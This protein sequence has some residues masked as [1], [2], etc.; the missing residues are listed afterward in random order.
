MPEFKACL[1]WSRK[2]RYVSDTSRE[3]VLLSLLP[4]SSS[5]RRAAIAVSCLLLAVVL[6]TLP[7]ARAQWLN[8]PGF[9]LVQKTLMLVS[10]LITAALLFGQYAIG[11]P[12]ALNILGGGY[13]FTAL[14]TVPHAL[15]FPGVFSQTGLLGA[16]PQS[17]AYL[18][19]AAH[20]ALPVT[21]IGF[22][23]HRQHASTAGTPP[24]RVV[25]STI[26]TV[27]AVIAAVIATA[28]LVTRGD[29]CLPPLMNG[30]YYT[31]QA[32]V[33][34]GTLLALPFAALLLLAWKAR[35]PS[36]LALWLMVTMFAWLCTITVGAFVSRGRYDVGWYVGLLLDWLTSIFV[37]L[38]LI[39]ETIVLYER[40]ASAAAVERR[41]RDRRI[42][43]MEAVLIHLSRV[44]ELGQNVSSIVHEL[45]QPLTAISNYLAAGLQLLETSNTE[46]LKRILQQSAEQAARAAELIRQLR[47]FIAGHGPEKRVGSIPEVLRHAVDLASIGI[48]PP[49]P[50][51]EMRL[52]SVASS[53]FFDR[54]QIEQV[55]FNLVRNAIEAMEGCERRVLTIATRLTADNMVEVS[56]ADTGT[57]VSPTIRTPLFEPF[58]TTKARGLGIGL[59]ICRVIVEAH[60]GRLR[61]EDNP[62]GGAIFRFALPQF[63]GR[64]VARER[65]CG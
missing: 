4:A 65:S 44:N 39:S 22:A 3:P 19:I 6:A 56:V 11:R 31:T 34:V 57:G 12:H 49:G 63:P 38:I 45:N 54:V 35:P 58:V 42:N 13:L 40:Q 50:A 20:T 10:D 62:G 51:I 21:A 47:D 25:G 30:G 5:Q 32:R 41:Q 64:E 37:L 53:A 7:F 26:G 46:R 48:D 43:E 8:L 29:Q 9:V 59:S 14:I 60:G 2:F 16:G 15:T 55:V 24:D 28:L 33:A 17:A 18:Y 61:A 23:L 52:S 1:S 36:M 27:L